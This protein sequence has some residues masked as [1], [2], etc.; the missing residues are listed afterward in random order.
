M[1]FGTHAQQRTSQREPATLN[2]EQI[3]KQN[4]SQESNWYD[5]GHEAWN[6]VADCEL[7][8]RNTL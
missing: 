7:Q 3:S 6:L 8:R 4:V 1:Q 2:R 5:E